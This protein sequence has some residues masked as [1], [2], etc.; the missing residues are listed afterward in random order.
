MVGGMTDHASD[1]KLLIKLI[2][3]WK[4]LIDRELRG[5]NVLLAKKSP[6]ELLQMIPDHLHSNNSVPFDWK[7]LPEHEQAKLGAEAWRSICIPFGEDAYSKLS[8][9][10]QRKVDMFIWSGFSMHKSLNTTKAGYDAMTAEWPKLAGAAPLARLIT[11]DNRATIKKG[12]E[13]ETERIHA[14]SKEGAAKHNEIMGMVMSNKDD[15][16][17]QQDVFRNAYDVWERSSN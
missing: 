4:R 2:M 17:G 7:L 13:G 12:S 5:Q 6:V 14:L 16:K 10:E 15:K 11:K 1:Q 9:A 3:N 8:P